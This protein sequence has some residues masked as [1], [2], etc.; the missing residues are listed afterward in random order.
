MNSV[1]RVR[2]TI[3]R[4]EPDHVPV[5]EW[6]VDHDIAAKV[7]GRRTIFRAKAPT[8]RALWRGERD[9]VVDAYATD[10][11]ELI[12]RLDHDLVPVFLVPPAGLGRQKVEDLG[13]D[14]YRDSYGQIW[15]P[16]QA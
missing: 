2:T 15:R 7:L 13:N 3:Q 1:E 6:G 11:I 12:R 9:E 16:A 14:S 8:T 5:G 4:R 10:L